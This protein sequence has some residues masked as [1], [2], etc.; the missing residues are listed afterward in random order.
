MQ[1]NIERTGE[2]IGYCRVSTSDQ[3]VENQKAKLKAHNVEKWFIDDGVSG[4][5]KTTVRE[6]FSEMMKYIR[7]GDT[8]VTTAIDRLGRNSLD[9]Q[10]TIENLK[11]RDVTIIIT[12]LGIDLNGT[13]G[14][15]VVAIMG[16]IAEMER[17]QMLERQRAG[18]ERAKLEGKFKGR[19]STNDPRC[20]TS[21]PT[22]R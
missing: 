11:E 5:V 9:I 2:I 13:L 16:S 12:S 14:G 22:G 3:H 19:V 8:L 21:A 6:Q 18:I 20:D 10:Q 4:T 15:I 7:S 17:E 1:D